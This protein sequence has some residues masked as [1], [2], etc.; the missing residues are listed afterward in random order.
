MI[1]MQKLSLF[2]NKKITNKGT[3][4]YGIL[5]KFLKIFLCVYVYYLFVL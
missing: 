2:R 3:K 1:H 5:K 4:K